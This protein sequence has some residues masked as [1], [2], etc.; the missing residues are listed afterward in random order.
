[1]SLRAPGET[2]VAPAHIGELRLRRLRAAELAPAEAEEVNHHLEGCPACRER[3]EVLAAEER[4][5]ATAIPFPRFA[6]GVERAARV[7]RARPVSRRRLLAGAGTG[8]V[9]VAAAA[10]LVLSL[11]GLPLFED[12]VN[13]GNRIKGDAVG[14]LQL[15]SASG[16]Q[17]S[18]E[19]GSTTRLERG[20]ALLLGYRMPAGGH[21]L[22]LSVDDAG[23]VTV[24]HQATA[25]ASR[26]IRHLPESFELTGTGRE[27][28][29]LFLGRNPPPLSPLSSAASGAVVAPGEF[30]AKS[31][32]MV[33]NWPGVLTMSWLFEKP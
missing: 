21:L 33:T 17:R 4:A 15:R 3:V 14:A 30:R 20:D 18:L 26:Q 10:G 29:Y 22:A 25:P 8:M 12:E 32:E 24:L 16:T 5:F 1:M 9:F 28:V 27:R 31:L 2:V 6:G 7:P 23:E 13:P 11:Q 19:P